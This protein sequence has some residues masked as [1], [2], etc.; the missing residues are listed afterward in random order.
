MTDQTVHQGVHRN[1]KHTSMIYCVSA[2][3][4]SLTP[5]V[6]SSQVND[7]V[8]ETLKIDG[9]RM[10]VD[11]A[12]EHRQKAYV[13]ATLFQQYVTS[14]L[15]LFIERV[16]TN[17][18]FTDKS[19]ILLMNHC[20]IHTRPEV[21]A[22]LRNH[23]VKVITFP[24]HTIQIF[25]TL[26]LCLFGVFKRKRQSKLPFANDNLTVNLI[27]NAFRALQQTFVRDNVRNAFELLRLEFNITHAPYT[28]LF[29]EDKLR[30]SQ[31]FQEIWETGYP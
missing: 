24:P 14:V 2:A 4:E 15:I 30:R 19:A 16:R 17:P 28:L 13:T 21:P 29:R 10:G 6:V 3:G 11:M 25:Q 20:F 22:T 27:R 26:D 31:G 1:L 18:E 7:K 8:I 9:F 5:F 23:N 12:L